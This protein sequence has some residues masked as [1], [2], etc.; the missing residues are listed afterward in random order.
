[1]SLVPRLVKDPKTGKLVATISQGGKTASIDLPDD[2]P[3]WPEARK[4]NFFEMFTQEA[5]KNL[6]IKSPY[7]RRR[8]G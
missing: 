5:M 4:E 3:S 7:N 8:I 1:M 2:F 6:R